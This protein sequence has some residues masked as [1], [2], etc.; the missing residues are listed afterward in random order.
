MSLII[1]AF[2]SSLYKVVKAADMNERI[3]EKE[4]RP[5]PAAHIAAESNDND[6]SGTNHKNS[7][8]TCGIGVILMLVRHHPRLQIVHNV[9]RQKD[10]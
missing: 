4:C 7:R 5:R 2:S 1:F 3:D 10:G 6:T 9:C 8:F